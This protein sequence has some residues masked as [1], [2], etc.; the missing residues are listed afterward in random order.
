[1][2]TYKSTEIENVFFYIHSPSNNNEK[3][4]K[5]DNST[6]NTVSS[7]SSHFAEVNNE[8]V[9]KQR[10]IYEIHFRDGCKRGAAD[11]LLKRTA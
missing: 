11:V 7:S 9:V 5:F 3:V 2:Q 10:G 8:L 1:M 6:L 4:V